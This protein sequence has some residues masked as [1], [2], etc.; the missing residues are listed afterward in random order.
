MADKQE[1]IHEQGGTLTP[2]Q[3]GQ[4][5]QA[6]VKQVGVVAL[7]PVRYALGNDFLMGGGDSGSP[8]LGG[9]FHHPPLPGKT[10][11]HMTLRRLRCGFVYMFSEKKKRWSKFEIHF[12]GNMV[13]IQDGPW[14]PRRCTSHG[15]IFLEDDEPAWFAFSDANWSQSTLDTAVRDAHFRQKHMRQFTP[16]KGHTQPHTGPLAGASKAEQ[17]A[18]GHASIPKD[19]HIADLQS[20][21]RPDA[22]WF[23]R[24]AF[25]K[26][27]LRTMMD[28]SHGGLQSYYHD[29]AILALEDP[30][31]IAMDLST[32]MLGR[33]NQFMS[34]PAEKSFSDPKIT[35]GWAAMT[36]S[37]IDA[38][39]DSAAFKR[40]SE[41]EAKRRTIAKFLG[42]LAKSSSP[43]SPEALAG[44][45][46]AVDQQLAQQT[47]R[48][49]D[50]NIASMKAESEMNYYA[51]N[52]KR[53]KEIFHKEFL[54]PYDQEWILP[55]AQAHASHMESQ[56][57]KDHFNDTFDPEDAQSGFD[58]TKTL[59]K[60]YAGVQDKG[61]CHDHIKKQL[62]KNIS[63]SLI[64]RALLLNQEKVWSAIQNEGHG[65]TATIADAGKRHS[66]LIIW[67]K[68]VKAFG[69]A[70]PKIAA[71]EKDNLLTLF[72]GIISAPMSKVLAA[73][74]NGTLFHGA[75]AVHAAVGAPLEC[76]RLDG[77]V[78]TLEADLYGFMLRQC[79][80]AP[81]EAID[82]MV[83]SHIAYLK[84]KGVRM[85]SPV[86]TQV[87]TCR[88]LE[89]LSH[90][91]TPQ[92]KLA[93]IRNGFRVEEESAA[94]TKLKP[95][96]LP[97][98]AGALGTLLGFVGVCQ[99]RKSLQSAMLHENTDLAWRLNAQVASLVG[100]TADTLTK[101]LE[102]L[103]NK[104]Y[105]GEVT[106]SSAFK[107]LKYGG[108]AIGVAGGLVMAYMDFQSAFRERDKGDTALVICYGLSG[109]VGIGI[110][111]VAICTLLSI[112]IAWLPIAGWIL[113]IA[114]IIIGLAI[115]H[116]KL[117]KIMEWLS[118]CCWGRGIH[119][120]SMEEEMKDFALVSG[121]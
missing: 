45:D 97:V 79:P 63:E 32:L 117:K 47:A 2:T 4:P 120:G 66:N 31:A 62:K 111:A 44:Y 1:S 41:K 115:N 93:V 100:S 61:P 78:G 7:L 89:Q 57:L 110:S 67:D 36:S 9:Q 101:V 20:L 90:E 70:A 6:K 27:S 87:L 12:S 21:T 19:R 35:W 71:S 99:T 72:F 11:T 84:L 113:A 65:L 92:Q 38:C 76:I 18:K 60:C 24:H 64:N 55:L 85:D 82:Q 68:L 53:W 94:L 104:G 106:Q 14:L 5:I 34:R 54:D 40:S 58:F 86:S 28:G 39:V 15:L 52:H 16:S 73:A 22:F 119:Y 108:G 114:A 46:A 81:Q 80:N 8:K 23:S 107:L 103:M 56:K 3:D 50:A 30:V 88:G 33:F 77:W 25:R 95:G 118:Q 51:E 112:G 48:E 96:R 91:V 75:I 29:S 102:G 74:R 69:S 10:Y 17:A 42:A 105:L 13:S 98:L 121:S 43:Y 37:A 109:I 116:F 26:T 59:A 49:L 83:A